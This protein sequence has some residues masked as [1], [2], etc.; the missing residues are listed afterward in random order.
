MK[1]PINDLGRLVSVHGMSPAYKQ[2]TV[3]IIVL[4]FLFFLSTMLAFYVFGSFLYFLLSS[5]FLGVYLVSLISFLTER[6]YAVRTYENG[7]EYRA[8][9][10]RWEDIGTVKWKTDRRS[11]ILVIESNNGPSISIPSSIDNIEHLAKIITK[12]TN[13]NVLP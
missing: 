12:S 11:R 13:K 3:F 4:S 5:G 10:S 1:A 8:F 9:S 6:R 7:M 2:Q